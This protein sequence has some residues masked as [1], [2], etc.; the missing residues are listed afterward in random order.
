MLRYHKFTIGRSWAGD[1]GTSD[2][3]EQMFEYLYSYS[4]YHNIQS[5][6][7]Y[8]VTLI[9]T[10]NHDDRV[11]PAHSYKFAAAMQAS[12]TKEPVLLYVMDK[13]GHEAFMPE[14]DRWAFIM[15]H[16]EMK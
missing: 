15:K 2:E 7:Q 14:Y 9:V 5:S 1:Y 6:V 4:P 11:I 13:K 16:L 12:G 3:S 8:P 10:G